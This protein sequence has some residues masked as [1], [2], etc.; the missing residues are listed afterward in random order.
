MGHFA[1]CCRSKKKS[2]AKS[3]TANL[4]EEGSEEFAFAVS[5]GSAPS[6]DVTVGGVPGLKFIIDS[7]ASC[8]VIDRGLW[9]MLKAK[10]VKCISRKCQKKL[11]AYGSKEPLDIAGCFTATV[12]IGSHCVDCEFVVIEGKGQA[13]LGRDTSTTLGILKIESPVNTIKEEVK[14]DNLQVNL[15]HVS[16]DWENS[17]ILNSAYLSTRMLNQLLNSQEEYP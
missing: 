5:S 15:S 6:V 9:E 7:G 17:K 14:S 12:Q 10:K 3:S 11:F 13:L 4:V 16:R 2:K 8:N 1:N